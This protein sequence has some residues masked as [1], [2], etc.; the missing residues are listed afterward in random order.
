MTI[1]IFFVLANHSNEPT[2]MLRTYA[3]YIR[4]VCS[5]WQRSFPVPVSKISWQ[6]LSRTSKVF[7]L[8]IPFVVLFCVRKYTYLQSFFI[9]ISCQ[10]NFS[11]FTKVSL[12]QYMV[13][14]WLSF[15]TFSY[16]SDVSTQPKSFYGFRVA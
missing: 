4:V 9:R 8:R 7:R 2:N 10:S 12:A 14:Q 3:N 1:R 6:T 5:K 16:S 13:F 11:L 15:L